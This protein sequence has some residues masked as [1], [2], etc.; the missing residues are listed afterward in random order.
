VVGNHDSGSTVGGQSLMEY[1][2][3]SFDKIL[4]KQGKKWPDIQEGFRFSKCPEMQ[5]L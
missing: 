2:L 5:G 4:V 1:L 3:R